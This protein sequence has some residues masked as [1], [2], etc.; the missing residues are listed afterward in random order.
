ML[1]TEK[2]LFQ[3]YP[4]PKVPTLWVKSSTYRARLEISVGPRGQELEVYRCTFLSTQ[5]I[6][7]EIFCGFITTNIG[8][9]SIISLTI[10]RIFLSVSLIEFFRW[11]V[12]PVYSTK[13]NCCVQLCRLLWQRKSTC[14]SLY[15]QTSLIR[16]ALIRFL[17]HPNGDPWERNFLVHF[18]PSNPDTIERYIHVRCTLPRGW[19]FLTS[20]SSDTSQTFLSFSVPFNQSTQPVGLTSLRATITSASRPRK[21]VTASSTVGTTR[22]KTRT[23][24]TR[25]CARTS[26]SARTKSVSTRHCCA[27]FG[28]TVGTRATRYPAVSPPS[29]PRPHGIMY[30]ITHRNGPLKHSMAELYVAPLCGSGRVSMGGT[31]QYW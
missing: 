2:I 6:F 28:M 10:T 11:L 31:I 26:G 4:V 21:S 7:P 13:V 3:M 12:A 23:C 29:N 16:A 22:T 9:S 14:S 27:T 18:V 8:T 17:R 24:A 15:S 19:L 5:R 1:N 30:E 20:L 25:R